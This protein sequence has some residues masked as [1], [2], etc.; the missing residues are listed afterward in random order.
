MANP[1]FYLFD[2]LNNHTVIVKLHQTGTLDELKKVFLTREL[3]DNDEKPD[4]ER[5]K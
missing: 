2:K 3:D 5:E 1:L 4:F